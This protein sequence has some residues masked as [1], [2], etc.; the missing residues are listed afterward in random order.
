M[1]YLIFA[2]IDF[3]RFLKIDFC[4]LRF[5]KVAL[6]IQNLVLGQIGPWQFG[7]GLFGPGQFGTRTI[8]Y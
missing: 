1:R 8:R 5:W 2:E 3:G 4:Y 6:P 7:P